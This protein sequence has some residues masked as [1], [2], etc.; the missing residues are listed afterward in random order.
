MARWV[1][2]SI[3][4]IKGSD[5][6]TVQWEAGGGKGSRVKEYRSKRG[7]EAAKKIKN[8]SPARRICF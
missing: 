1:E 6:E 8:R 5:M 3:T 4:E 2:G 7:Q